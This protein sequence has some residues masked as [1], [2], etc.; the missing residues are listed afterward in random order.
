MLNRSEGS[1]YPCLVLDRGGNVSR[2]SSLNKILTLGLKCMYF[3]LLRKY[4]SIPVFF[5]VF[6]INGAEFF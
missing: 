1:L 5:H 3:S 6:I 2:V 4:P